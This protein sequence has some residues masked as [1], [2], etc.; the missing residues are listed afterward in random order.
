MSPLASQRMRA[1]HLTVSQEHKWWLLCGWVGGWLGM[2][3]Q[4]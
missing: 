3:V 1:V 2:K 4:S